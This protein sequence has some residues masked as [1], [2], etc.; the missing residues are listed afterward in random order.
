MPMKPCRLPWACGYGLIHDEEMDSAP[1]TQLVAEPPPPPEAEPGHR[2]PCIWT[3]EI[4]MSLE[5]FNIGELK[6]ISCFRLLPDTCHGEGE[7]RYHMWQSG[8]G[9]LGSSH[10]VPVSSTWLSDSGTKPFKGKK[11]KNFR[12]QWFMQR[13]D[14]ILTSNP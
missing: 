3:R 6:E 1:K 8:S 2:L 9:P 5:C 10:N 11:P 7:E 12:E 4:S 14:A 13:S